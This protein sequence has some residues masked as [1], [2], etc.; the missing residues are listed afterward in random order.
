MWFLNGHCYYYFL[1]PHILSAIF[2][3]IQIRNI[4]RYILLIQNILYK[5]QNMDALFSMQYIA[6]GNC[7]VKHF[8]CAVL[9]DSILSLQGKSYMYDH[10]FPSNSTQEQVYNACAK[11]I[12]KGRLC[13]WK[14][15]VLNLFQKFE[16]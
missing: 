5:L 10:V 14:G 12:V 1:K 9:I 3:L 16:Y 7:Y 15:A 4:I 11:N 2:L 6:T 13:S 8:E